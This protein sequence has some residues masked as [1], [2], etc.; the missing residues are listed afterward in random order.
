MTTYCRD[1][2]NPHPDT[3]KPDEPWKWRCLRVPVKPGYGYVSPD[4][5]PSP[6]YARCI[7]V[8]GGDCTMFEPRREAPV[9]EVA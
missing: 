5:S 4:F 6:P 7:D 2:D 8:N 1:C 3:R 9:K